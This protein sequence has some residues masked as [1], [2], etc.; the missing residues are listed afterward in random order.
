MLL[1]ETFKASGMTSIEVN[2]AQPYHDLKFVCSGQSTTVGDVYVSPK[3][4]S[5]TKLN[6]D[7]GVSSRASSNGTVASGSEV[8]DGNVIVLG[9]TEVSMSYNIEGQSIRH[10]TSDWRNWQVWG[11]QVCGYVRMISWVGRQN[12][13]TE[14][15]ALAFQTNGVLANAYIAVWGRSPY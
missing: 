12:S 15:M 8:W 7:T 11:S 3:S 2:W 13:D 6:M 14:T 9:T 5:G 4:A 1:G 10:S